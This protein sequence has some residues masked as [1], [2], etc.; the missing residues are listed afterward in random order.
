MSNDTCY[1]SLGGILLERVLNHVLGFYPA[2]NCFFTRFRGG[3]SA[4]FECDAGCSR[5]LYEGV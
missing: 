3:L 2:L 5:V 1:N 4:R